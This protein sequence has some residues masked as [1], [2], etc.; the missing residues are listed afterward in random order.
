MEQ[1]TIIIEKTNPMFQRIEWVLRARGTDKIKPVFHCL[2]ADKEN[3]VCT[4]SSRL[5]LTPNKRNDDSEEQ[6][7][8]D[9]LYTVIQSKTN[10]VLTPTD[11]GQFPNYKQVI[12]KKENAV[13]STTIE[14]GNSN[15]FISKAAY[16]LA[17]IKE[18]VYINLDF[19]SDCIKEKYL[20]DWDVYTSEETMSA[21]LVIN[22]NKERIA[23]IMPMKAPKIENK[24]EN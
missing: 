7:I 1:K 23:V 24:L 10:I 15:M 11:E 3:V 14:N 6:F 5:H 21:F 12:P 4:D 17:R 18:G 8:P 16:I 19:L 20:T 2:Y 9:G 22:E 13:F